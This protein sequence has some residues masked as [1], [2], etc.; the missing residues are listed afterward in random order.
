VKRACAL[1]VKKNEIFVVSEVMTT[2]GFEQ[3]DQPVTK[4]TA[5]EPDLAVGEAVLRA[6]ALYR[7]NVPP[8]G[9]GGRKPDPVLE[10]VG[11]RTW[12]QLQRSSQMVSI[13][14]KEPDSISAVPTR[15]SID[16]GYDYLKEL[17]VH[18]RAV[19]EEIGTA[20]RKAVLLCE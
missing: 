17:A 11:V 5:N 4:L 2:H 19:P 9:P 20:I 13:E 16:G 15:R 14:E 3:H 8:F 18:C 7:Q 1:Y 10:F 6:L 12:G